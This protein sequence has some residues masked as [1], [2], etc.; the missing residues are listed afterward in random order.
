MSNNNRNA[1]V[2]C[3][4]PTSFSAPAAMLLPPLGNVILIAIELLL[5]TPPIG[6]EALP[7]AVLR[8]T[9]STSSVGLVHKDSGTRTFFDVGLWHIDFDQPLFTYAAQ[10]TKTPSSSPSPSPSPTISTASVPLYRHRGHLHRDASVPNRT[11]N[12][13]SAQ[14]LLVSICV[15][16]GPGDD[17]VYS[18]TSLNGLLRLKC[19]H[20]IIESLPSARTAQ[21]SI[22]PHDETSLHSALLVLPGKLPEGGYENDVLPQI[23]ASV[24]V[25][26]LAPNRVNAVLVRKRGGGGSGRGEGADSQGHREELQIHNLHKCTLHILEPIGAPLDDRNEPPQLMNAGGESVREAVLSAAIT[27]QHSPHA[28]YDPQRALGAAVSIASG[29]ATHRSPDIKEAPAQNNTGT[30]RGDAHTRE[31]VDQSSMFSFVQ[32]LHSVGHY[33]KLEANQYFELIED[34]LLA[35][36]KPAIVSILVSILKSILL[37][38]FAQIVPPIIAMVMI[39]PIQKFMFMGQPCTPEGARLDPD[40]P[41]MPDLPPIPG[42]PTGHGG[43]NSPGGRPMPTGDSRHE[44][45]ATDDVEGSGSS[46]EDGEGGT[47]NEDDTDGSEDPDHASENENGGT[48]GNDEN[49]NSDVS[50]PKDS[51]DRGSEMSGDDISKEFSNEKDTKSSTMTSADGHSIVLPSVYLRAEADDHQDQLDY[52]KSVLDMFAPAGKDSVMGLRNEVLLHAEALDATRKALRFAMRAEECEREN[53]CV[54]DTAQ[55]NHSNTTAQEASENVALSATGSMSMPVVS[56]IPAG[57]GATGTGA[58]SAAGV[59]GVFSTASSE[60]SSTQ[61]KKS[62]GAAE[63]HNISAPHPEMGVIGRPTRVAGDVLAS[64]RHDIAVLR[65]AETAHDEA[66]RIAMIEIREELRRGRG[67]NAKDTSADDDASVDRRCA[68]ATERKGCQSASVLVG[69]EHNFCVWV[70]NAP[71]SPSSVCTS[72]SRLAFKLGPNGM[73]REDEKRANAATEEFKMA[74]AIQGSALVTKMHFD[75]F[76]PIG[77]FGWAT[78]KLAD[79]APPAKKESPNPENI[80]ELVH[81]ATAAVVDKTYA[82]LERALYANL[83]RD[84]NA[85]VARVAGRSLTQSITARVTTALTQRLAASLRTTVARVTTKKVLRALTPSLTQTLSATLS[86]ALARSPKS[87]YYCSLC[88]QHKLYCSMCYEAVTDDAAKEYYS[89]YYAQYFSEYYSAAYASSLS[90]NFVMAELAKAVEPVG[91]AKAAR[92]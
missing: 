56:H 47:E 13:S 17:P 76:P 92:L 24:N 50:N 22:L 6:V 16:G 15:A 41:D 81:M 42:M 26:S 57:A 72:V 1:H 71:Q 64:T 2:P 70:M 8:T 77:K 90:D 78:Q 7:P 86:Q 67:V 89:S 74:A 35:I 63:I 62:V 37:S 60:F 31:L 43:P 73:W 5:F 58:T 52:A 11:R 54:G 80:V 38:L 34:P 44:G 59:T 29:G 3:P 45:A 18:P 53:K 85:T 36:L 66:I 14:Q 68:E 39:C 30:T 9:L 87:D 65:K 69:N 88:R 4:S 27:S 46:H 51:K 82:P 61:T 91:K 33:E 28:F 79:M 25:Q 19:G 32:I 55:K 83:V 84:I 10:A 49:K 23:L 48:G 75:T 40:M 20:T 21:G 12:A